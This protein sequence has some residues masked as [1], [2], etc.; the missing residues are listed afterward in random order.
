[1]AR[2]GPR[3]L[4][5]LGSSHAP[6]VESV[7]RMP[8]ARPYSK[9]AEYLDAL[10]GAAAPVPAQVRMLAALGPRVLRL[11]ADRSAGAHP[12]L[13]TPEH[14]ALARELVGRTVL[15]RIKDI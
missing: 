14:T 15:P 11:A 10:D 13:T 12:Y 4:L 9:M 3:F 7:L 2:F 5:G 1:M 8:Y 6:L